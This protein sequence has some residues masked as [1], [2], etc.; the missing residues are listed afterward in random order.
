MLCGAIQWCSAVDRKEMLACGISQLPT[1]AM[2]ALIQYSYLQR[3]IKRLKRMREG[4]TRDICDPS[5]C[6]GFDCV[7]GDIARSLCVNSAIDQLDCLLQH[8]DI[9]TTC[10]I[11]TP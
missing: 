6:N 2:V 3:Y 4:A 9:N 1:C 5:L 7:Y 10:I 8:A 11:H